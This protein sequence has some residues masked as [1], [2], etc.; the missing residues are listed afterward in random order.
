MLLE[1]TVKLTKKHI[2]NKYLK[3]YTTE[4]EKIFWLV[5]HRRNKTFKN[6]LTA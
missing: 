2:V 6:I 1:I 3:I 5:K 4:R